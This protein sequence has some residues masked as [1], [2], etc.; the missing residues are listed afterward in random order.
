M[1]AHNA[2]FQASSLQFLTGPD[3]D[4]VDNLSMTVPNEP[5]Q[6]LQ[7]AATADILVCTR[8]ALPLR[9]HSSACC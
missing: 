1:Q 6:W 5:G 8:S 3:F 4:N 2:L 7:M 9:L